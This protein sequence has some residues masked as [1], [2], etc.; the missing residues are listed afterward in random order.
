MPNG[1][2]VLVTGGSGYLG[3]HLAA[4][5]LAA[6]ARVRLLTRG[7]GPVP[8]GA[9]HWRADLASSN[10]LE[11]AF[12]GVEVLAHLAASLSGLPAALERNNVEATR[13][14]L[15]AMARSRTRRTVLASSLSV[16]DWSRIGAVLSEDSPTLDAGATAVQADAYARTKL[17][18]ERL[19]RELAREHGWTLTIL[20]PAAIWGADAWAEFMIG[21]RWRRFQ[22]V[23]APRAPARLVYLPNAVDAF[24]KA[25]YRPEGDELILNLVDDAALTNWQYARM[26]RQRRGGV[27]IPVPYALGLLAARVA[28]KR[29]VFETLH[30]PARCPNTRLREALGWAPAYA[31]W[32]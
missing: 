12:D 20:R 15:A 19:T 5:L 1:P 11:G 16:Y 9:E 7:A 26:V 30:K 23:F 4:A 3:R 24:V 14:L 32:S 17:A 29:T 25:V 8:A 6:G 21:K 22:A 31:P 27:L 13:R 18:Q 28:A 2:S 10:D